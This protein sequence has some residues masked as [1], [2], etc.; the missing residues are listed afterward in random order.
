MDAV[1]ADWA[2]FNMVVTDVRP[3]QGP[4]TMCMTGPANHPFGNGVLGI[5]P[6]DCN[7]YV[8][9]NVVFAFHNLWEQNVAQSYYIDAGLAEALWIRDNRSYKLVDGFGNICT[10]ITAPALP[11][12]SATAVN[13]SPHRAGSTAA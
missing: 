8:A 3:A 9:N 12:T 6:L 2:P 10:R 13:A 11:S 5:A 1:K 4:Y 7:N